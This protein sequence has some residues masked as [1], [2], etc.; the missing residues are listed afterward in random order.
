MKLFWHSHRPNDSDL[1]VSLVSG[2]LA[3]A[4]S[5]TGLLFHLTLSAL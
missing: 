2:G 4:V 3:G 5:S 1:V